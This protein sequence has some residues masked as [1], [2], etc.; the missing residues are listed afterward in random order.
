MGELQSKH[1]CDCHPQK[2][3]LKS[4]KDD[5]LRHRVTASGS[6]DISARPLEVLAWIYYP[7]SFLRLAVPTPV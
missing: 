1:K 5:S 6:A 4:Q 3:G 2:A 7:A